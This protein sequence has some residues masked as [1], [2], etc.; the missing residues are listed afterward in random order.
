ML[1]SCNRAA[2]FGPI[3]SVDPRALY[4]ARDFSRDARRCAERSKYI[5]QEP[6]AAF[7]SFQQH[8]R[9]KKALP[10]KKG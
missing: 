2:L 4:D 9:V 8:S 1:A 10:T 3:L 6:G 7:P 5:P